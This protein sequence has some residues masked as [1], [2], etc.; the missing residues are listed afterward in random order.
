VAVITLTTDFGTRDPYVAEMKAAILS[1][2]RDV[3][4]VDI[5]HEVAPHDILEGALALEAAAPRFPAAT[6]HVAV[7][8]PGVGTARRGLAIASHD[9][10][11]VGPDNGL[12]TPF[13]GDP[14]WRAFELT[15][16][17]FRGALV[18]Q[19]FHGR[20]IFAP[21]AAHLANQLACGNADLSS[22]GPRIKDP[23]R[24]QLEK[25]T[26]GSDG[27]VTGTILKVDRFGN[28]LTNLQAADVADL[29]DQRFALNLESNTITRLLKNYM[30][31]KP[32]EPFAIFGSSCVLEIALNRGNA[33]KQLGASPGD[34]FTLTSDA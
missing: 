21:A 33:A 5:T 8:D 6:I 23:V 13:L 31:G 16:A 18:S 26:R 27:I 17:E 1:I 2:I 19:T 14:R 29:Q 7:V 3:H 24:L 10:V 28:L 11:F 15:A 12:F 22:F 25:P 20:D 30:A 32:G 4:V 34:T 9:Q